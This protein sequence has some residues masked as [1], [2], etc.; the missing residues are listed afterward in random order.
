MVDPDYH[1]VVAGG[2]IVQALPDAADDEAL[3]QVEK[4]INELG[5]ITEYLKANQM[6][7]VLWNA[8]LMAL[9]VNEVY[10]EPIHFQCRCGRDRSG[11]VLMTLREEDKEAILEDEVTELV[12]HLL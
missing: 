12:C 6:V 5:P 7:R 9:T 8:F 2:F 11:A 3:A 1:T 10:N 4:N